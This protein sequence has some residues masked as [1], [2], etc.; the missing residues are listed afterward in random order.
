MQENKNMSSVSKNYIYNLSYQI[1]A[2]LFPFVT[3]PYVSRILGADGIGAY[4]YTKSIV[5]Y[6]ILAG[7]LGINIYGQRE[8]A[9]CKNEN[10]QIKTFWEIVVIRFFSIFLSVCIFIPIAI[11]NGKY[12]ILFLIQIIDILAN[13]LDISWYY[14]GLENFKKVLFR[15]F[16]VRILGFIPIFIFVKNAEDVWKYVLCLC[17]AN[18][19]G[20]L[21]LWSGILKKTIKGKEY[22]RNKQERLNL[23]K[24][25]SVI[26]SMF[27]PQVA[28]QVYTVFDKTMIGLIT[29]SEL[30]NGYYE[31]GEKLVR[32]TASVVTSLSTVMMPRVSHLYAKYGIKSIFP[33]IE[34]SIHF[35][36][37]IG[38]PLM[39]GLIGITNEFVPIFFGN[40]FEK[41]KILLFVF[42][43]LILCVGINTVI[44]NQY[45]ISTGNQ[46]K[47]TIT[48]VFG[49]FINVLLNLILIPKFQSV[50]AA[51]STVIAEFTI[52]SAQLLYLRRQ[53]SLKNIFKM[54]RRYWFLG[55][56]MLVLILVI[57]RITHGFLCLSLQVVIGGGYYLGTLYFLKD[58]FF[59]SLINRIWKGNK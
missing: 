46:N 14:Q 4:S 52:A 57:G 11:H 45:L 7:S 16:M 26:L 2:L 36:W 41:V 44:G 25:F 53:F 51:L 43:F 20:N 47:Y 40:S 48:V 49:A 33:A 6:F 38:I 22:W 21:S 31:Q 39:F 42:S 12:H 29:K 23:K 28:I 59:L 37:M 15:N 1:I 54:S 3:M 35:V 24:H 58:D 10:E 34:K 17:L 19:L 8:I 32:L 13:A 5:T 55:S 50:G 30:E 56:S 27:I 9:Y 18:F